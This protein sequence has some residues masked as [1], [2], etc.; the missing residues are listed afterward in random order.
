MFETKIYKNILT[1]KKQL[2]SFA[3]IV[4]FMAIVWETIFSYSPFQAEQK[5]VFTIRYFFF[6]LSG[7]I[8]GCLCSRL[9][10]HK[11]K[12]ITITVILFTIYI[13]GVLFF[14][15]YYFW[16]WISNTFFSTNIGEYKL[17]KGLILPEFSDWI[18][19]WHTGGNHGNGSPL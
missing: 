4:L 16:G 12:L 19:N 6:F 8:I 1:D 11:E 15:H 13:T 5:I 17:D 18:N 9:R 3:I 7:I 10:E 14:D 2:Y